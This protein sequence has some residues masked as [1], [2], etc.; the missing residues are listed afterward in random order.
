MGSV[1][2]TRGEQCPREIELL[3]AAKVRCRLVSLPEGKVGCRASQYRPVMFWEKKTRAVGHPG[4]TGP[5]EAFPAH[6]EAET[7]MSEPIVKV[8]SMSSVAGNQHTFLGRTVVAQAQ[9]SA[10]KDLT[11]EGQIEGTLSLADHCLNVGTG[12]RVKAE[13]QARQ[14]VILGSVTGN[15]TARE[16]IEI[17]RSG[18]VVGDV[19]AATVAIEDGAYFKG[20]VDITREKGAGAARGAMVAR[21]L[22][23]SV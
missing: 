22:K 5:Q 4:S 14:I 12:G 15:L 6:T 13:I 1:Q 17:R 9:L 20:S 18:Q 21:T 7:R 3:L 8:P 10:Q 19:V 16:K 11:V 2:N 23:T